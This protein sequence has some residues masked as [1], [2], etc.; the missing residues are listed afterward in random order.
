M[1]LGG[2]KDEDVPPLPKLPGQATTTP[3]PTPHRRRSA[4]TGTSA[5]GDGNG[6]CRNA[7]AAARAGPVLLLRR[8][9][10]RRRHW[11]LQPAPTVT[12]TAPRAGSRT[13]AVEWTDDSS[14]RVDAGR[15]L[16]RRKRTK[17]RC[18]SNNVARTCV[19]GRSRSAPVANGKQ[20]LIDMKSTRENLWNG[21]INDVR[22][23]SIYVSKMS[24]HGPNSLRVEG[25]AM[26][27]ML[28]GGQTWTRTQ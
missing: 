8:Q 24:L 20:V 22:S 16:G 25:C 14:R 18:V 3:A 12:A 2:T 27:G 9:H 10:C 13:C 17:A 1:N 15:R 11:R 26:G 4:A 7:C 19:A 23:G 5:V 28:C 6:A 21:K